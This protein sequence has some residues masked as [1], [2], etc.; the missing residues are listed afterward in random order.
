M[1]TTIERPVRSGE[2]QPIRKPKT[3]GPL[4]VRFYRSAVGKKWVMAITGI[5]IMLFLVEHLIGNLTLFFGKHEFNA[6]GEAL[7]DL[8]G[9]LLPRTVLLWVFRIGLIVAF[10]FHIHAAY[11][12]TRINWKARPTKY[13]S[14]RDYVAADFASR[15]M[16]WTGIIIALYII[17]H[18]TDLTWGAANPEFVRG[19]AYNNMIYS[20]QRPVVA[21]TYAV[22]MLALGFHLY[23]GS[24]SLFQSLGLNNPTW[25]RARRVFAI[26]FA[27]IITAGF[28]TFPIAVQLHAVTTKC[29]HTLPVTAEC[30][31]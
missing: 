12:L 1:A 28:L 15:T 29:P 30:K 2:P 4:P 31:S 13:Q 19:D 14:R 11:G 10:F 24:W 9:D 8:G 23:H 20:L 5:A 27:G 3:G 26:A 16:R 7:R 17:F 25:N 18:L 6:Y 21:I 22:A